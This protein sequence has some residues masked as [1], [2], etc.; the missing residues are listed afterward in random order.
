[1]TVPAAGTRHFVLMMTT[2]QHVHWIF[3]AMEVTR[4][5]TVSACKAL[6]PDR[7]FYGIAES[8]RVSDSRNS[9]SY[10]DADATGEAGEEH[11]PARALA[12]SLYQ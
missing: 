6:L 9:E 3:Q 11:S 5:E 1:M 2:A 12:T 4:I 10:K 8:H 7:V